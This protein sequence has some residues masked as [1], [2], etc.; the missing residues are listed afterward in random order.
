MWMPIRTL[1]CGPVRPLVARER[2]L[3]LDGGEHGVACARERDEEGVA[4]SVDLVAAVVRKRLAHEP[5]VLDEHLRRTGLAA[6]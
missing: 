3:G 6:A 5:L 2:A 4:L 1:T